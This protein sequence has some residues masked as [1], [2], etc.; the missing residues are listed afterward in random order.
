MD[1]SAPTPEPEK[2][3]R[4]HRR[5][6]R[7]GAQQS[8]V[9][10]QR[11]LCDTTRLRVLQA[12]RGESLTVTEL[13]AAIGR[14]VAA[15]SQHLRVLRELHLV[16]AERQGTYRRYRLRPDSITEHVNATLDALEHGKD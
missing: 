1:E 9:R 11:V 6:A 12:L 4:A 5:I 13:A 2:V 10:L 8:L 15:T 7:A 3:R 14:R 16:E